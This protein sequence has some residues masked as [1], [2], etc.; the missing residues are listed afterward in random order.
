MKTINALI[1]V[2]VALSALTTANTLFG[3]DPTKVAPQF[4]KMKLDE[5]GV[6]VLEVS[7]APGDKIP[8][9][10]HP[11]HVGYALTAGT[12]T[13][14]ETGKEPQKIDLKVG[15]AMFLPAQTHQGENTGKTTLKLVV[16]ELPKK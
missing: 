12:L 15:D 16:V 8:T 2:L 14:T 5:K 9:H 4:Y 7:L 13:I 3:Q 6:R 10:S 11:D 1:A